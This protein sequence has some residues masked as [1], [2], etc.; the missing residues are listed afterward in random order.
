LELLIKNRGIFMLAKENKS[1]EQPNRLI[2]I[3]EVLDLTGLSR[4]YIYALAEDGRFPQSVSLVRGGTSRAWV[5]A[6][7]QEWINNRIAE[8]DMEA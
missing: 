7:V 6:E 2:R 8:R 5:A 3:H 1:T 4:S